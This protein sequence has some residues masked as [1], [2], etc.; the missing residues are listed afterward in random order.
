MMTV[1]PLAARPSTQ[2]KSATAGAADAGTGS[3]APDATTS[4][5]STALLAGPK[6]PAL[7]GQPAADQSDTDDTD[8]SDDAPVTG[9]PKVADTASSRRS[10]PASESEPVE[11]D[12]S[13]T[14]TAAAPA[15]HQTAV[16]AAERVTDTP[17]VTAAEPHQQLASVIKPL[18]RHRGAPLPNFEALYMRDM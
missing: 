16:H 13:L 3:T 14:V 6:V 12:D 9:A 4:A 1:H 8:T 17:P 15:P 7:D 11:A 10:L 18:S 2:P 5:A